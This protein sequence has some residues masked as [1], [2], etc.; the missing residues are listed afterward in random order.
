MHRP[1]TNNCKLQQENDRLQKELQELRN[2]LNALETRQSSELIELFL[3][4]ALFPIVILGWV[5]SSI[6]FI[7]DY[8]ARFLNLSRDEA[9]GRLATEFWV[10]PALKNDFIALLRT[11]GVIYDFEVEIVDA[12]K[13]MKQAVF[14]AR[15]VQ[16]K[17][18]KALYI[19]FSDVTQ[20]RVAQKALQESESRYQ[21][22]YS[23]MK[24]MTDTQPDLLWAKDLDDNFLF[25]NAAIQEKLLMCGDENPIG[26]S[27][28]FFAE[29]ERKAGHLHSFGEICVNSDGII[30]RTRKQGRF[31]EDGLVRGKYLA[32]DVH[33]APM[34]NA[35]GELIGTVGAGRNVTR[36]IATQKSLEES[37]KRFRLLV[38]NILDVLWISDLELNPIYVTPS[39]ESLAGYSPE[40]FLSVPVQLHMTP[41]YQR[42]FTALLRVMKIALKKKQSFTAK[43]FEFECFKKDKSRI[44]VEVISSEMRDRKGG[45]VGFTGMIR[46]CTRR[47]HQQRELEITKK[48]A[49]EASKA[50]SEFLA[51]MSHELRTPMNGVLGLLQLLQDTELSDTQKNYVDTALGSGTSL[52]QIISDIL[53]FSK[54]EAGHVDLSYRSLDFKGLLRLVVASFKSLVEDKAV[55]IDLVVGEDVPQ[56]I[57]SDEQRLK[58]ILFNLIGNALKFTRKGGVE[59]SVRCEK[60]ID[61]REIILKFW[62]KDTGV[63]IS[64]QMIGRLFEPFVQED[65]GFRRKYG[66]TGLGLS[67]VK[68]L[69]E[70]MGGEIMLESRVG[71]GTT[72]SFHI[73]TGF[74]RP[75]HDAMLTNPVA[76]QS[77][78]IK[79][80]ILVVEDE[81]INAMV[82]SAMLEK[83]GHK[84]S[85]ATS[86]EEALRILQDDCF[87]CVFMDIQM[88]EMDGVETTSMIR[89]KL[90][91]CNSGIPII[92][93]TAHAMKGDKERF[94]A[95]GM[96]D[97]ISKPVEVDRLNAVLSKISR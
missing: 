12:L 90:K 20:W 69:V 15:R 50:K 77:P 40:E 78:A 42:K 75:E 19:V 55:I 5:D 1:K 61:E 67:I 53:D 10:K 95:A 54:I 6:L 23:L 35:S 64:E 65:G 79:Q 32:L 57:Y 11:N 83:C 3:E 94:L 88:P 86:G 48:Q 71:R 31:L 76:K 43:S 39:I 59:V 30:K 2:G 84:V 82:I 91:N 36:D 26:K 4:D 24:L 62:I 9:L 25:A 16:Y 58:Q 89:S 29:R 8:A 68:K 17:D 47:V 80:S 37:E 70:L 14:T 22:L 74:A 44:W 56:Y 73:V 13:E 93:L 63:G 7:N 81:K 92:A 51:N 60:G 41:R 27:D 87:D 21:E 97:Y 66:G 49:L 18:Q 34:F 38:S 96:D 52:L 33:K 72:V 46:D 85:L 28:L 45:L